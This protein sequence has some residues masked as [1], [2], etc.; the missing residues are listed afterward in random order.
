[1]CRSCK[2]CPV[3]CG[4]DRTTGRG[5]CGAG[6]KLLVAKYGLH[7]F[8]EPCISG[9][10]GS[11]TVFFGGCALRCVFCQ[12][13]ELSHAAAGKTMAPK[14]LAGVFEALEEAGAE[15]I[16]LVTASHFVPQLIET[17]RIRRPRIPVVYNTH[18]YETRAALEALDPYIDVYLPDLKFY[19]PKVS[20]RYTGRADYF[21]VAYP[22]VAFMARREAE[23]D[24]KKMVRGCIVRHLVLPLCTNDSLEVIRAF[25]ALRSPA[26]FSLLRQYTPCGDIAGF[27]ELQRPITPREYKKVY[28]FVLESGLER[29]FVQEKSA[30]DR[31]FIPDFSVDKPLF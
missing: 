4:A 30:A 11:G 9:E 2:L 10:H 26:W 23:F 3:A 20:A 28:D 14:E 21:K 16:N 22:A 17:F 31:Q 13:Y 7:P 19:A 5:V 18:A 6:D 8:E 12:N 27:P 25:A 15:N 29:V 24:G 1:M